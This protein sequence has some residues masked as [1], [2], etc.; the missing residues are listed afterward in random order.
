MLPA[1]LQARLSARMRSH[2][3]GFGPRVPGAY[4]MFPRMRNGGYRID[5]RP[6]EGFAGSDLG[7][8]QAQ[9]L[10]EYDVDHA[11]L[12]PMQP[13]TFG[14]EAPELADAMCRALNDWTR[15]EWLDQDERLLGSICPPHEHPDLA[16]AEIER[17]AGDDRF[18]QVLLPGTLEQGLG[19][20][21]YWPILRAATDA[22]LP[23]A[24]HTGG[25]AQPKGAGWP[26]YYVDMHALLGTS[27]AGQMLSMI[28]SGVFEE[29]PDLQ[30]VAVETG[31]AWG[32]AL[33][34]SIDD[35]WRMLREGDTTA[36]SEPPSHYLREHWWFTTQP[37][38]EPDDPEH[39]A[40]A[41]DALGMVD[42]I[43]FSSDY[44]HWDFDAP[45]QT[46]PPSISKDDK[47]RIL[48]GN[49][50]ALSGLPRL[51]GWPRRSSPWTSTSRR[52]PWSRSWRTWTTTGPTTSPTPSCASRRR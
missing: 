15:E 49:A 1:A 4:A 36:I 48:A 24:L 42:R 26:A 16:V 39:L 33:S 30:M 22:G 40:L 3:A 9:L 18:V 31:I 14:A 37:I 13:Q 50:C 28:C 17:L 5:A 8:V 41:F 51:C 34:W 7:L 2:L 43:V 6:A 27:M 12:T 32:V 29:I 10:D 20:R 44:P 46:L 25:L 35:A 19:N 21:R 23:V 11:V 47:A 52:G 38:E 45:S